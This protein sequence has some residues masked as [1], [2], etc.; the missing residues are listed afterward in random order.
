[1]KRL[2]GIT[3]RLGVSTVVVAVAF[4][5][6]CAQTLVQPQSQTTMRLPK[7]GRVLV[8]DFAVTPDEVHVDQGVLHQVADAASGT[9][10]SA[11]DA[12]LA[13]QVADRFADELVGRIQALGMPAMR[14]P[15]ATRTTPGDLKIVGAFLDVDQGNRLQRLVIGFGVGGSQ[16]DTETEVLQVA[17]TGLRKVAQFS[18]HAD[19][20]EMPGAAVTMGAG[21]AASGG[22]TAAVAAANIAVSGVKGYR[23]DAER[24]AGRSADKAAAY[25]GQLFAQQG[26]IAP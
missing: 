9:T 22:V 18:T 16:V 3:R 21:A 11:R 6:G 10:I 19:S 1:M 24:M 25:L 23:S 4:L 7:P 17:D 13:H 12:A 8:Y 15:R 14:A 26:W 5:A 20:G 2:D